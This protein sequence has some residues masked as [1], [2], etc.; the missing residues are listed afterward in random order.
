MGI[1]VNKH[2]SVINEWLIGK[3]DRR[4]KKEAILSRVPFLYNPKDL[5]KKYDL[6]L[7]QVL[8]ILVYQ[9]F[10]CGICT[11]PI[12]TARR[13]PCIDH[14]HST[15]EV[16]G[17]LCVSCNSG[18]GLLGDTPDFVAKAAHYLQDQP[19]AQFLFPKRCSSLSQNQKEFS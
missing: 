13:R 14:D 18:L 12:E 11:S 17:I 2:M 15:G 5:K 3:P 6:N 1:S 9:D 16:R 8:S 7:E 19:A 10:C 4:S